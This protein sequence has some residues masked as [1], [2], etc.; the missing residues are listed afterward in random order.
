M[1]KGQGWSGLE[2]FVEGLDVSRSM[3][4]TSSLEHFQ[5]KRHAIKIASQ[6][7]LETPVHYFEFGV[8]RGNTF[9]YA[10]SVFHLGSEFYGF[11]SF[12][13][14]PEEWRVSM[15]Y[16]RKHKAEN[17]QPTKGESFNN[18]NLNG[19]SP[20][21]GRGTFV[22]G[23]FQETLE[24]FLEKF[25]RRYPLVILIDCDLYSS[26]LYLLTR[27]H[28]CMRKGDILIFDELG[29]KLNEFKAFND[30]IRS[31]YVQEKFQCMAYD[32]LD[33]LVFVFKKVA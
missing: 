15:P 4:L 24:P 19:K 12:K 23:L 7:F 28:S 9:K 2:E 30:Y 25:K 6:E 26:T 17:Y 33:K 10:Q 16:H 31:H 27:L 13:G 3:Q 8:F 22:K 14:L 21:P 29:D 32:N 1:E 5:I 11:D 20:D 18:F